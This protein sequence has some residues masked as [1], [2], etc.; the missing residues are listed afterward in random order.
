M[1]FKEKRTGYISAQPYGE[2]YCYMPFPR[3]HG[4]I[5]YPIIR[6]LNKKTQ[7]QREEE[8]EIIRM[9]NLLKELS[10]DESE[11]DHFDPGEY[12]ELNKLD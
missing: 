8:R 1:D 7:K 4:I 6:K 5:G 2:Y 9:E 11:N 10:E 12:G 3:V